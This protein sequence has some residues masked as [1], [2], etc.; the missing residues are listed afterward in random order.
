MLTHLMF[1]SL[2]GKNYANKDMPADTSAKIAQMLIADELQKRGIQ[3][4]NE[5]GT[6]K[7]KQAKDLSLDYFDENHKQLSYDD[8]ASK[9]LA[10]NK[11]LAV[12]TPAVGN[13]FPNYAPVGVSTDPST[14]KFTAEFASAINQTIK[15][16]NS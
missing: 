13:Q 5:N 7:L 8:F 14:A 16:I 6:L 10:E 1:A 11:L 15:D 12:S 3:P 2:K 4:V 9:I